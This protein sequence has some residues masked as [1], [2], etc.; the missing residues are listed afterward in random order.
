MDRAIRFQKE[1]SNAI[2]RN[3]QER[4]FDRD[5]VSYYKALAPSS[6]PKGKQMKNYGFAEINT[7]A[8]HYGEPKVSGNN[9]EVGAL[10]NKSQL[11]KD[12]QCC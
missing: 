4:F 9:E 11:K 2:I 8:A 12:T 10:V 7:L 6:F 3:L 5:S 1:L